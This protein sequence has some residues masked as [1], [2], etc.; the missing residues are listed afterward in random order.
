MSDTIEQVQQALFAS[1][2][3]VLQVKDNI[4][5][6]AQADPALGLRVRE[7]VTHHIETLMT[8]DS[9]PK[10]RR[11]ISAMTAEPALIEVN[12]LNHI[13]EFGFGH[14][15]RY[16]FFTI[17]GSDMFWMMG[18]D[19]RQIEGLHQEVIATQ[20]SLARHIE[21]SEQA[22]KEAGQN[23]RRSRASLEMPELETLIG[24]KSLRE[25]L[26][27]TSEVV[28]LTCIEEALQLHP[29]NKVA[30]AQAL[31]ITVPALRARMRKFDLV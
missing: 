21:A 26:A 13:S 15:F 8:E 1:A 11:S 7:W 6:G 9:Q 30:A 4:V 5:I 31:G 20:I 17:E 24:R 2:D 14:P 19:L 18:T 23:A 25:I 29:G 10:V 28:E 12:D 16:R 22:L 3:I 27:A